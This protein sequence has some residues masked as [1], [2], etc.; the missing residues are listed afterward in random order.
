[1]QGDE[2]YGEIFS[3]YERDKERAERLA[4]DAKN[5]LLADEGYSDVFYKI[6]KLN[7]ALARAEYAQDEKNAADFKRERKELEKQLEKR[8]ALLGI[9][10]SALTPAYSC[11]KCRDTGRTESGERCECFSKRLAEAIQKKFDIKKRTLASFGEFSTE[12][13][14]ESLKNLLQKYCEKFD[15]TEIRNLFLTGSA[16]SGKTFSSECVANELQKRGKNVAL[17]SAVKLNDLFLEYHKSFGSDKKFIFEYLTDCDLL[18]IDDLGTE[19]VFNNVT[20]EYLTALISERLDSGKSFIITT[21]LSFDE[22][23]QRYTERFLSRISGK[24]TKRIEIKNGDV[25]KKTR[26]L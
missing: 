14:P 8:A 23:K 6:K 13:G 12:L 21:N 26:N 4:S 22:I 15:S 20:V 10:K 5:A 18:V 7:I 3:A 25:R 24:Q 1:M 16:G 11:E 19:P 2:I 17:I 9:E